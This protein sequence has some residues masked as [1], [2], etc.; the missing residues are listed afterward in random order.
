MCTDC[1]CDPIRS[2]VLYTKPLGQGLD[3]PH[4]AQ[5]HTLELQE[6]LLLKNYRLAQF[7]RDRFQFHDLLVL[8]MLSSPGSGK[9]TLIEQMATAWGEQAARLGVIVGDLA[10]ENDA[11][12]LRFAGAT[13][14]Q[15]TTGAACHLE[16]AMINQTLSHLD[17][18]ALDLLVIENVGNLVCPAAY[19]LGETLRIV[20]LSVTE[21]EDKPQKYPTAFQSAD[22]VILTKIDIAEAVKFDRDT[23]IANIHRMAPQAKI[24]ELSARTGVGMDD[25]LQFLSAQQKSCSEVA[26][27]D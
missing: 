3:G 27:S 17:L 21:G 7:N 14:L 18:T 4:R 22:V 1:G 5:T 15:I 26:T 12:R 24:F 20:L 10:T 2:V 19:D 8:N 9:T 25:W 16:A 11:R 23:A 13:A 6:H